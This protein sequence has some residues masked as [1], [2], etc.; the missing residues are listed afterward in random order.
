[1]GKKYHKIGWVHYSFGGWVPMLARN[2]EGHTT[3]C[4]K[5]AKRIRVSHF[6]N[7]VSC[8]ICIDK[9]KASFWYCPQHKFIDDSHVSNDEKCGLCGSMLE[10]N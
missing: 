1:M 8:P 4:G 3:P 6:P 7:D 9:L 10:Y 2:K 5:T